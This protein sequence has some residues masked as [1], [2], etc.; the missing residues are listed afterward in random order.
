MK[1][2]FL[3]FVSAIFLVLTLAACSGASSGGSGLLTPENGV[4]KIDLATV[5][6]GEAHFFSVKAD[7]GT[8][9]RFFVL[10][11][12]DGVVRAAMDA[13]DVCYRSGK[14]YYREGD[15]MVCRNC[16]QK[17]ASNRINEVKGG[18]N[19]A[20]LARQIE[21]KYLVIDMKTINA[22]KW[23]SAFQPQS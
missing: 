20:P 8:L 6:D 14:G 17:F 5:S 19:P 22:N 4:L 13:C 11:S 23:Y 3:L 7:D 12:K 2:R 9:A 16:G 21:G 10:M 1:K 15:F 18:C